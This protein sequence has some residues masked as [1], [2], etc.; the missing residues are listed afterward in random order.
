MALIGETLFRLVTQY[1][2][3]RLI[4]ISLEVHPWTRQP[5]RKQLHRHSCLL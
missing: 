3:H 1:R 4:I 5:R 2:F